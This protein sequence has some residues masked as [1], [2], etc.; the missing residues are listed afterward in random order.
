[1]VVRDINIKRHQANRK[2]TL[3]RKI[4]RDVGSLVVVMF[5]LGN[6]GVVIV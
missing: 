3:L 5:K 1:M 2:T 6:C 4:K